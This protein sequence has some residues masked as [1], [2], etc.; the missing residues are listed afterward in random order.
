MRCA[1]GADGPGS[2]EAVTAARA[3]AASAS[4]TGTSRTVTS[5]LSGA[6]SARSGAGSGG[7]GSGGAGGEV[8][9]GATRSG[10]GARFARPASS[11]VALSRARVVV[12]SRASRELTRERSPRERHSAHAAR[13]KAQNSTLRRG[14]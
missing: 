1:G 8:G 13:T 2:T 4:E 10:A 9:G 11:D 7:A 14:L 6:G 3:A 5:L 12:S